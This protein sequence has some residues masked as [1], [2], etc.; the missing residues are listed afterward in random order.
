MAESSLGLEDL[1]FADEL[2]ADAVAEA[3]EGGVGEAAGE[4][5]SFVRR[6]P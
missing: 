4:A 1:A 3:M 2:G 5:E 6:G